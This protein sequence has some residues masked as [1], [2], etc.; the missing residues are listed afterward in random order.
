MGRDFSAVQFRYGGAKGVVSLDP[1]MSN[2][3]DLRLRS[4][5][6]KFS[7][8]HRLFE[9]CKLSAPRPV[10]LNRQAI[11]LLSYRRVPDASFIILQQKTHLEL[12]VALLRNTD[13]EKLILDKVPNWFLPSDIQEAN[14]DYIHEPFFRQLLINASL[15]ATRDLLTRTRIRVPVDEGRNMM[16]VVD[17]Y[18]VLK[19]GEVFVQFTLLADNRNRRGAKERSKI[20]NQVKVAI[21]KNPCHHPGDIRTFIAMDYPELRHLKDVIVFSQ[22]GDRPAPHDI[23]GSDLDGDEYIVLWEQNLV[24]QSTDNADPYDYD[25]NIPESDQRQLRVK[26]ELVLEISEQDYLGRLSN[27]HLAFADKFG[28]DNNNRSKAD[29]RSTMELAAAISQ[30]VD[31]AKTGYHP[32]NDEEMKRLTLALEGERP[33]FMDKSDFKRYESRHVLGK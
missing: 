20:L 31:S 3:I 1:T 2:G 9:V 25:A 14:I 11:L 26:E 4:S 27:L 30:E 8:E 29:V 33:D 22:Q 13:A 6:L 21:T 24:P 23:S 5:M 16:G 32:V 15:N 28:V 10:Y 18:R 7:S 19:P 17:E 12:I